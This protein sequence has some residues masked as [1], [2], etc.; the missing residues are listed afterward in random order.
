MKAIN[1]RVI[2]LGIAVLL[3]LLIVTTT[4]TNASNAGSPMRIHRTAASNATITARLYA[5]EDSSGVLQ[6]SASLYDALTNLLV[7]SLTSGSTNSVSFSVA[8]TGIGEAANA[9]P[10]G[11]SL[12]QN[13]PNPFNPSTVIRFSLA[14]TDNVLLSVYDILGRKV[15]TL[16]EQVLSGGTYEV[17]WSPI[18]ASGIYFYRLNSGNFS[19]TKKMIVLDGSG[20]GTGNTRFSAVGNTAADASEKLQPQLK[21]TQSN[22]YVLHLYSI[23]GMT[24]PQV[25]GSSILI[26]P[27]HGDTTINVYRSRIGAHVYPDSTNQIIRGFGGANVLIFRPDMTPAQVQTAFGSGPGQLG[28][29]IMRLSIPPDS[30]QFR[31]NATSAKLAESLGAKVFATPW[32]PPAW[33]KTN[34]SLVGG[35]VD[36]NNYAAWAAYLKS[37]ADTMASNGAPLYAIS[38]QNEPDFNASYQ[39]CLWNGTQFLNFM[40]NNAPAV[41][42]PVLMPESATFNHSLSD[43]TLNDSVAASRV[44]FIGGHIYGVTPSSYPLALSKG[45]EVWMTEYLI[46]SGNPPANLNIDT[47]WTGALQ[48]AKNIHDCMSA[49]MSAYVWWYLVRYYGPIDDGAVGGVAGRVTHKGYVMSQ[50][51]RFVRPGYYRI[52]AEANPQ[53]NVYV[54]AYKS[55]SKLVIVAVNMGSSAVNQTFVIPHGSAVV[56]SR[57]VTSS[58]KNCEEGDALTVSSLTLTTSLD[59]SSITTFVSD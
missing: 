54:T 51:A 34:G 55:G 36:P 44:A 13:F 53:T 47:G 45:K 17:S 29:T 11:Y 43:P 8:V 18:I 48:T 1:R 58:T 31:A 35:S 20:H 15:V 23:T 41:G 49:S 12:D 5:A 10:H 19:A 40:K 16:V 33:M 32:S 26:P 9:V 37:F 24:I 52:K 14:R 38:V 2:L 39:S 56:Y 57:F 25:G 42:T 3:Y 21:K 4:S 59:A 6:Y 7:D 30:T 27:P 50:Y 28:L 22:G 46:N